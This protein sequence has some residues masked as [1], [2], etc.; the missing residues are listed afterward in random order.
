MNAYIREHKVEKHY[1]CIV[2]GVMEQ[3]TGHVVLWHKK[4]AKA[5]RFICMPMNKR[6]VN[7]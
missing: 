4:D 5:T 3:K 6:T 1:V 7:A 2:E